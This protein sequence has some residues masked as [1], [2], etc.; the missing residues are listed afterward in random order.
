[1][2]V[3]VRK[4]HVLRLICPNDR[5][6]VTFLK[7]SLARVLKRPIMRAMPTGWS[8]SEAPGEFEESENSR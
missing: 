7:F 4:I 6:S 3:F 5:K 1:M 8:E 2:D